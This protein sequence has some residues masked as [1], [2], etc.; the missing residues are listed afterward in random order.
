MPYIPLPAGPPLEP[1]IGE[2]TPLVVRQLVVRLF[3][4]IRQ[5]GAQ[6]AALN[7]RRSQNSRNAD[8]PP[9]SDPPYAQRAA[10]SGAQG[11]PGAKPGHPGHRQASLAPTEMGFQERSPEHV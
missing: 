10:R 3:V 2:Q 5:P 8:R 11:D 1:A 9:S 4:V 6:I 7:A